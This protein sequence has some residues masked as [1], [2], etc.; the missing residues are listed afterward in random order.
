MA[1]KRRLGNGIEASV[2]IRSRTTASSTGIAGACRGVASSDEETALIT[3]GWDRF[4]LMESADAKVD[5]ACRADTGTE[6]PSFPRM[7]RWS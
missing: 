2:A 1:A 7:A 3:S 4:Q 6:G 5:S